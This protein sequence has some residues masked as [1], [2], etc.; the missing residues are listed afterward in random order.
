MRHAEQEPALESSRCLELRGHAVERAR[1]PGQLVVGVL[2]E[3][4]ASGEVSGRDAVGGLSHR[5][6]RSR[7][8][9]REIERDDP[10]DGERQ[11]PG[12]EEERA[13]A[14]ERLRLHLLG[15]DHDRR[16]PVHDVERRGHE[17]GAALTPALLLAGKE[18]PRVEIPGAEARGQ[19]GEA[20][21]CRLVPEERRD[22][23]LHL[24]RRGHLHDTHVGGAQR[25]HDD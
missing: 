12:E 18:R 9:P 17:R 14:A 5:S 8:P 21:L 7:Q 19:V 2:A 22:A 4:D 1:Q 25:V 13:G 3:V 16:V 11:R 23:L 15:E 10:G 24:T 20:R 6:E